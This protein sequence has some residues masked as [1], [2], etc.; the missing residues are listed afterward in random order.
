MQKASADADNAKT[1]AQNASKKVSILVLPEST[2]DK[3]NVEVTLKIDGQDYA[4]SLGND[5]TNAWKAGE[6]YLYTVKLS[7]KELSITSVTVA[8]WSGKTGGSL[9]IQ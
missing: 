5:A 1:T 7:G 2:Q 3:T 4:V 8:Q 6:N 9:E